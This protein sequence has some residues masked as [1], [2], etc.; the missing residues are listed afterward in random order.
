MQTHPYREDGRLQA[1]DDRAVGDDFGSR[2]CGRVAFM[3]SDIL[4]NITASDDRCFCRIGIKHFRFPPGG[5]DGD[6][7]KAV[8]KYYSE[9]FRL[10]DPY[11]CIVFAN[12][13]AGAEKTA[14]FLSKVSVARGVP[15]LR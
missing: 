6:R 15:Q 3:G 14:G 5:P 13:R 7:E 12:S 8:S 1:A 10:T 9:L 2:N 11:S 4:V